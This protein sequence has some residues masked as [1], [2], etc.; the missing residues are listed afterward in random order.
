MAQ[1]KQYIEFAVVLIVLLMYGLTAHQRNFIWNNDISLWTD[2]VKKSPFKAR[3]H[4]NL[5]LAYHKKGDLDTAIMHYKNGLK[6]NPF[7]ANLHNDIGISYYDKGLKED[8]ILHFKHAIE[9][10][11]LHDNAH[12]NLGIA[13]GEKGMLDRAYEEM[14]ISMDLKEQLLKSRNK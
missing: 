2:V 3:A 13:Y 10:N 1:V 9:I 6:I 8:A 14:R 12:Y 4:N 7:S 5:G 11:P